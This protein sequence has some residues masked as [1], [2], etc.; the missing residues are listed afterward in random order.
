MQTKTWLAA[1]DPPAVE[2][3]VVVEGNF[4]APERDIGFPGGWEIDGAW[5]AVNGDFRGKDLPDIVVERNFERLADALDR[6]AKR[7]DPDF[8]GLA[9]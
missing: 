8:R 4:M 3:D 1:G 7:R 6:E 5:Y 9:Y 2:F